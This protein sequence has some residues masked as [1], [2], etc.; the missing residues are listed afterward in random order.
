MR[1]DLGDVLRR[2]SRGVFLAR[3]LAART[4][5]GGGVDAVSQAGRRGG[6]DRG[7]ER[8]SILV[9]TTDQQRFD[10]LGING[11]RIARTPTLDALGRA[12]ISYHRAHV[13]NVVCMPSRSTMLT[14]QH[15]R[16]HGVIAN[17][18][19]LPAD[20]PSVAAVLHEA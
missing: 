2:L 7:G 6:A 18:V 3:S 20:A 16:T 11:G 19:P 1:I 8:R 9:I 5:A 15:P 14:G 17:G 10:S 4:R 12:G 13:Q